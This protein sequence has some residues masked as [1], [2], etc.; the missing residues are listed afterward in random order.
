MR[1]LHRRHPGQQVPGRSGAVRRWHAVHRRAH[2]RALPR[3][4]ARCSPTHE[5]CRPRTSLA[6]TT[7]AG[8]AGGTSASPCRACRASPI[9]TISIRCA[10]NPASVSIIVEPGQPLPRRRPHHP[11]RLQG[12]ARR[13]RGAARRGLGHRHHRPSPPGGAVLGICGGYQMLGRT[14]ADPDGV[15]GAPGDQR[16]PRPA[17]CRHRARRRSSSCAS[18]RGPR[19]HRRRPSRGYH[20]HMG[21]DDRCRTATDP[22][23]R[24]GGAPE[25]AV[26]ADGR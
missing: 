25:G 9:S 26:S 18:K 23:P 8:N 3:S 15:E 24:I 17:R 1:R 16:R 2:R 7:A 21:V 11:A 10:P 6:S 20:M 14:I 19:R 4:G 13:S 12:D 5:N 22:L